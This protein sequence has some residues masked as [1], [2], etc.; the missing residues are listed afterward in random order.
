MQI[1]ITIDPIIGVKD[2]NPNSDCFELALEYKFGNYIIYHDFN[3]VWCIHHSKS[4]YVAK[5]SEDLHRWLIKWYENEDISSTITTLYF[6][7]DYE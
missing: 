1:D 4:N 6:Y 2:E 5:I 3:Y 7:D